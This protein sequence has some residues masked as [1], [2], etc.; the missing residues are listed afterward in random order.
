LADG[1]LADPTASPELRTQLA[2][3]K[4]EAEQSLPKRLAPVL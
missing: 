2:E 1:Y 4:S 3:L